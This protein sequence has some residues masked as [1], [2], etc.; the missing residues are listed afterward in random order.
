MSLLDRFWS[1]VDDSGDCWLWTGSTVNGYGRIQTR[2]KKLT[3]A[4]RISWEIHNA[5][6]IPEGLVIDHLCRTPLCVN[7]AHLEVV[8]SAENIRR[9]VSPSVVHTTKTHCPSG[10]PYDDTNTSRYRGSRRCLTC[11]RTQ[12]ATRRVRRSNTRAAS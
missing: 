2:D 11:R 5:E 10:H 1:K 7:P 9:G 4:H 6:P 12:E 3:R 8:T